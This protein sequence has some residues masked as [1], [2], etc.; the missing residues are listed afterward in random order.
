M[1]Y[2][3]KKHKNKLCGQFTL[4]KI[5]LD[6]IFYVVLGKNLLWDILQYSHF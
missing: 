2:P 4:Q 3:L 1:K 6:F 5:H